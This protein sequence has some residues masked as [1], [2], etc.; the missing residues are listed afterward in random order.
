MIQLSASDDPVG[1]RNAR[2][3]LRDAP[4]VRE[5]RN[6]FGVLKLRRTQNQPLGLED[7]E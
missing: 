3:V 2:G 6:R 4:V 7:G 5:R 1:M